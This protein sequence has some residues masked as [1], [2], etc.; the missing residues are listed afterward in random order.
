MASLSLSDYFIDIETINLN[1]FF[2]CICN[3][4]LQK[5]A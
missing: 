1:I 2:I 3:Y 4:K 5:W